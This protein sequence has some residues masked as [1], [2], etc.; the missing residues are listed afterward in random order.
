MLAAVIGLILSAVLFG[1]AA[2]Y[3]AYDPK[4][5]NGAGWDGKSAVV[6]ARVTSP[7]VN[8]RKSPYDDDFKAEACPSAAESCLKRSYLVEGDLVLIGSMLGDFTCISY[9]SPTATKQIW[10]NGWL[11]SAS[12]TPVAPMLFP[13]RTDWIG[14]WRHPGGTVAITQGEGETLRI[15]GEM[16]VPGALDV[17][18]GSIKARV[19]PLKDKITFVEDGSIPF[20]DKDALQGECRVLMQR[21]NTW[22]MIADNGGC[23]GAGVSFTGLYRRKD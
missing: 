20:D 2:A 7:R 9:Q 13:K 3:D 5:C 23:G 18:T 16:I 19:T 17:H 21:I 14:V 1:G 22:L 15:E 12:L 8:F 6:V 4:N 10:A 11:P